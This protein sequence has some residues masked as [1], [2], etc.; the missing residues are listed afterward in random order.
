MCVYLVC[1]GRVL[2]RALSEGWSSGGEF[3]RVWKIDTTD[4]P[5]A[6]RVVTSS[7]F[8]CWGLGIGV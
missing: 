1:F 5:P 8:C 2:R 7:V 3:G 4:T 6:K